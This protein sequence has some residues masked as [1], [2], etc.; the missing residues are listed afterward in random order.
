MN[1]TAVNPT[2]IH[3]G[4]IIYFGLSLY[5]W[6]IIIRVL[7]TW[8]N[9]NPYS[10]V[11]RFLAKASDPVLNRARRVFPLTLG[12][13]DFSPVLAIMIIHLLGVVLGQWLISMGRGFPPSSF[14]PILAMALISFLDSIAWMLV[15]LMGIRFISALVQP[16]PYNI[17]VRIIYGLTEPLL[18]PLRRFFPPMGAK[19]LDIRP[20]IFLLSVLL[21]QWVVLNS[22]AK[23]VAIWMGGM[24]GVG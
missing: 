21:L 7:L 10:P 20:L 2:L 11:M 9:P 3:L 4:Q 1:P 19:G 6:L 13:L 17:L 5:V 8:I 12:G 22:L 24:S 18:S 14:V 16:S 15:I 23:G